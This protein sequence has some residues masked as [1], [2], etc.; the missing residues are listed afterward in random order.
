MAIE[1]SVNFF[2]SDVRKHTRM[3]LHPRDSCGGEGPYYAEAGGTK[4]ERGTR[5]GDMER[6]G[7]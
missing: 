7:H 2:S 4:R 1:E 5:Y 3:R 6:D